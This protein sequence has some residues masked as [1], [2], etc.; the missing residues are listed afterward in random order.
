M[1]RLRIGVIICS[2]EPIDWFTRKTV[3]HKNKHKRKE[4]MFKPG[5][6]QDIALFKVLT[7]VD[8]YNTTKQACKKIVQ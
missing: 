2:L 5:L 7:L 3:N 4:I 6:R 1:K 8:V